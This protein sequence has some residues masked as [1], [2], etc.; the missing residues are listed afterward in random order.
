MLA[1][2]MVVHRFWT[3]NDA[4]INFPMLSKSAFDFPVSDY[5]NGFSRISPEWH[6][7]RALCEIPGVIE[8]DEN[9]LV[10]I[11]DVE[12]THQRYEGKIEKI[13]VSLMV[14]LGQ[15]AALERYSIFQPS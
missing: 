8:V 13:G 11:N 15:F 3:V 7:Q 14:T 5:L 1:A 6:P 4:F 2:F 10:C 9:L 12:D